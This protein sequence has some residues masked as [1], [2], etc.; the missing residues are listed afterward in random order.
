M[1]DIS[2][3]C[4]CAGW[5][6]GNEFA[7]W[8][9]VQNNGGQYGIGYMSPSDVASLRALSSAAGGWIVWSDGPKFMPMDEWLRHYVVSANQ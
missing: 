6:S 5:M 7:L 9:L 8:S 3:E 1:S 2:E 4:Y